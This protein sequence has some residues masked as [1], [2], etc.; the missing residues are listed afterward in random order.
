MT[1]C[2]AHR[3]KENF[4]HD[5]GII[6]PLED[7]PERERGYEEKSF[8]IN[9]YIAHTHREL[10]LDV[11]LHQ[12]ERGRG[13]RDAPVGEAFPSYSFFLPPAAAVAVAFSI[14]FYFIYF[15]YIPFFARQL[16]GPTKMCL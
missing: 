14:C 10:L 8:Y 1:V 13:A 15:P 5:A 3:L 9:V 11:N 6:T 12:P 4:Y 7:T 2:C 16:L